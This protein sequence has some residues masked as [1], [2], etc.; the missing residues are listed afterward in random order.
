MKFYLE[1]LRA[2]WLCA[3]IEHMGQTVVIC[4]SN[5]MGGDFVGDL[6]TALFESLTEKEAKMVIFS[7]EKEDYGFYIIPDNKG[8]FSM[9]IDFWDWYEY[10]IPGKGPGEWDQTQIASKICGICKYSIV[11]DELFEKQFVGITE[12]QLLFFNQSVLTEFARFKDGKAKQYYKSEWLYNSDAWCD[13]GIDD[14]PYAAFDRLY[15]LTNQK[16]KGCDYAT[17]ENHQECW[18]KT[19]NDWSKEHN[20]FCQ[21]LD[22]DEKT[23]EFLSHTANIS[24]IDMSP[25]DMSA[26]DMP[27][28]AISLDDLISED[29]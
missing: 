27:F 21:A 24:F 14:F 26:L 23:M 28:T 16:I 7:N 17:D 6:M 5:I 22:L 9:G 4:A 25:P 29:N 15:M 11:N 3:R 20:K 8:C 18:N 12:E 2:G 1:S 10:L 13:K 19:I